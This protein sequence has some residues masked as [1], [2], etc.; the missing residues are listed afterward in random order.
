[1]DFIKIVTSELKPWK[2]IELF[3]NNYVAGKQSFGATA[4]FVGTMRDF[5]EGDKVSSMALEYYP[6]MTERALEDIVIRAN[7]KWALLHTLLLHR[8]GNIHPGDSIVLIAAW[9]AH[10]SAAFDA[11]RFLMEEL[12]STAPFWKKEILLDGSQRWVENNTKN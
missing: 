3:E 10:R 11:C 1:M 12:K 7:R 6:K 4:S 2:E 9:S 8:V 5:N